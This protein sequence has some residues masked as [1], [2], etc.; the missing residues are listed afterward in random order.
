MNML[1]NVLSRPAGLLAGFALAAG[2]AAMSIMPISAGA[3]TDFPNKAVRLVVGFPP[4]GG[5]DVA[6]RALGATLGEALGQAIVVENIPGAGGNI[7]TDRVVKASADGYT[8]LFGSIALS[9][10]PSLY[11]SLTFDPVKQLRAVSMVSTSP[12]VLLAN[13]QSGI[14]SVQELLDRVKSGKEIDFASAGNGSGSHL[15]MQQFAD[16]AGIKMTHIPY[17]GAAP[18]LNDVLGNQVPLVFDSIMTT[19]PH[20]K[21]G[22]VKALGLSSVKKSAIAPEIPSLDELGIKGMDSTSWFIVFAPAGTSDAV[23]LKLEQAIKA[24]LSKPELKQRFA[25]MGAEVV[26]STAAEA[27]SFYESEVAK[28]AKVVSASGVQLD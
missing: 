2:M 4:G 19:L 12:F 1:R 9:I 13:A 25:E 7:A 3:S 27:Q 20:I 22:S 17:R 5:V 8:L 21:A 6:A 14:D 24:A 28:W 18:A 26:G 11:K 10:N 15:F 16:L 23:V